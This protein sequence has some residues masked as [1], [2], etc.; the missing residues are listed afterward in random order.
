MNP[1]PLLFSPD[2]ATRQMAVVGFDHQREAF[3]DA[4]GRT[5]LERGAGPERLRTVQSMAAP[6]PN[7]ILPAFNSLRRGASLCSSTTWTS[8]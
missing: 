2:D 1:D 7:E 6:P 8:A 4:D 5:H 3:G